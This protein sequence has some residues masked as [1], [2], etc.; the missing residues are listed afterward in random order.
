MPML[1]LIECDLTTEL[2]GGE[3]P[4]D[5]ESVDAIVGSPPYFS[6]DGCTPELAAAVG[7]VASRILRPA[8]WVFLVM[9]QVREDFEASLEFR[10]HVTEAGRAGG[11]VPWQTQ[12]WV[13][14]IAVDGPVR[15]QHT[16]L[17]PAKVPRQLNDGFEFVW[18]WCKGDP[19]AARPL[20][21]LACGVP[22]ADVT[23]LRR[24]TRGKNGNLRCA[25]SARFVPY[26]TIAG[27][28]KKR[29]RHEYPRAVAEWLVKMASVPEGG[30]VCDLFSGGGTTVD[31][32]RAL[33]LNAVAVDRDPDSIRLTAELWKEGGGGL[34]A[35]RSGARLR[36]TGREVPAGPA[37]PGRPTKAPRSRTAAVVRRLREGAH[38]VE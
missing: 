18:S 11:L 34:V 31:V 22:Y 35:Q 7:A 8:G 19:A 27:G 13:K 23:N 10:R 21:R 30:T 15:G 16:A 2:R 38:V 20:G 17:D 9:G 26:P 25:G 24:G 28:R 5:D 12:A 6:G 37:V 29:H 32:A 3:V 4:I 14:S 1:T 33:G 36:P